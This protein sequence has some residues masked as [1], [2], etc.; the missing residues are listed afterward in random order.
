MNCQTEGNCSCCCGCG[1][2]RP[3]EVL[4]P[5]CCSGGVSY[6]CDGVFGWR[7]VR[8]SFP[9]VCYAGEL[10]QPDPYSLD[11]GAARRTVPEMAQYIRFIFRIKC[12]EKIQIHPVCNVPAAV[13]LAVVV[14]C[15][16]IGSAGIGPRTSSSQCDTRACSPSYT[17]PSCDPGQA[18][19]LF[20]PR[21]WT[22]L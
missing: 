22:G 2:S 4:S 20:I 9:R 3:A 14:T 12:A 19:R 15:H 6:R 1:S 10:C 21:L 11:V 17:S 7:N 18:A 16:R 5:A 8:S 13:A